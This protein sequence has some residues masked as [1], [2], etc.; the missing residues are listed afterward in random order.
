MQLLRDIKEYLVA[1][2]ITDKI[3]LDAIGEEP[4]KAMVLYTYDSGL[5]GSQIAG[6]TSYVQIVARA[7]S[8]TDAYNLALSAMNSLIVEDEIVQ[9][10][11]TRWAKVSV[12]QTPLKI[13]VDDAGRLYYGFNVSII[14]STN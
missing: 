7:K 8:S 12:A 5:F 14:T 13:K 2:G 6:H 4:D 10:T 3:T 1:N 11:P 9:L